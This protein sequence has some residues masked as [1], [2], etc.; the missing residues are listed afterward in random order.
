MHAT[1]ALATARQA[2]TLALLAVLGARPRHA[3]Q[4][5]L[6]QAII[7]GLAGAAL[8]V[9]AGVMMAS[10]LLRLLGGDLGGGY[11]G[12]VQASLVAS[13]PVLALFAALGVGT[14]LVG[15]LGPALAVR[16]QP[17]AQSLRASIDSTPR[18]PRRALRLA[19]ALSALGL[20]LTF[21]PAW[22]GLPL[23]AYAAIALWLF[24]G[25][26]LV[27]P[28]TALT[29]RAADVSDGAW[30]HP[31]VWLALQRIRG[32]RRPP[33]WRCPGWSQASRWPAR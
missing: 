27:G 24:A 7:L 21:L 14:A 25:I 15:S 5:V 32:A 30:R 20:L 10:A 26:A 12:G 22:N 18:H 19:A 4:C 8:G 9:L 23:A 16:R 3:L 13:A 33:A 1:I 31:T 29:G 2:P 28:I 6:A 11:F 17:P